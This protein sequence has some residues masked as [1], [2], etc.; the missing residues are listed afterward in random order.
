MKCELTLVQDDVVDRV[1]DLNWGD[2][3]TN[4][5]FPNS[6]GVFG[7]LSQTSLLH[8]V[9]VLQFEE[10]RLFRVLCGKCAMQWVKWMVHT[11]F[12]TSVKGGAICSIYPPF[13]GAKGL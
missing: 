1:L 8:K 2:Q 11:V 3:R 12:W 13:L 10:I 4:F 9:I 5:Y 7:S 6:S